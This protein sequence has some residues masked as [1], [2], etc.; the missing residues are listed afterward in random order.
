MS[1]RKAARTG[2][3]LENIEKKKG[4]KTGKMEWRSVDRMHV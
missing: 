2:E 4:R 1:G 3:T